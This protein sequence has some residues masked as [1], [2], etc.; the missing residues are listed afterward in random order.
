MLPHEASPRVIANG[1]KLTSISFKK[2]KIIDS[3]SF[4]PCSLDKLPKMFG[5]AELKKGFFPHNFNVPENFSYVGPYPSKEFYGYQ[6]FSQS[7]KEEF[8][9]WHASKANQVFN[10]KQEL[11]DYCISDVKLL[12]AA[13]LAFRDIIMS[14]TQK[15][16]VGIDPWV[17]SV[18]G[19]SLCLH[20]F[21]RNMMPV[22]SI[23][24]IPDYGYNPSNKTSLKCQQ[25][26]KGISQQQNI[27]IQHACNGGEF[28]VGKYLLDGIC[29]ENKTIYEF[30]GCVYHGC[31]SCYQPTTFNVLKQQSM[32]LVHSKHL[33][34]I[35]EIKKLMPDY[36]LVEIWEC[37][38]SKKNQL[39]HE[40]LNPRE[41]LFG[42]RTNAVKLYHKCTGTDTI[43]YMDYTSL[44][45]DVMKNGIF[46]IGHPKIITENFGPISSYF[47]LIKCR[48]LPPRQMYIPVLPARFNSKLVFALC[49]KCASEMNQD[50][51]FHNDF[52]RTLS[53]TW[54]SLEIME[55]LKHGYK[56]IE[57][58]EVWH[59]EQSSTTLF[60]DYINTFLKIKTE[61]SGFPHDD[62]DKFIRDFAEREGIKLDKDKIKKNLGLRSVAKLMLNSFWGRF[63]MNTNKTQY[64][65]LTTEAEWFQM[66][67]NDQFVIHDVD[68]IN[69]QIIQVFFSINSSFHAGSN[70]ANVP[71]AAF[72]TCQGRLKLFNELVKLDRRLLYFDTDSIIFVSK[73]G[74]FEPEL[75]DFLGQFTNEIDKAKGDFITEFVSAGPKNYAYK[76]NTGYSCCTVK[77]FN[78]NHKACELINFD[79]IKEIVCSAQEK[80]IQVDQ[81]KFARNK[82]SWNITTSTISKIY[83]FV[84]DK[85]VIISDYFT[86]PFGY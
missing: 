41:A 54:V 31:P 49:S 77:G 22:D 12:S 30:H 34:R 6:F 7:K 80:K 20:I 51:C 4:F 55:A 9:Q 82:H 24:V 32:G 28:H 33:A 71:I 56:L 75:G 58:I 17:S 14:V 44:Y 64:K 43:K 86:L 45:P 27:R 42:G 76:L 53:G 2:V 40:P 15:D 1:T 13:V 72:V 25:W 5:I 16:G 46:P 37:E 69:E 63:G 29:H 38:F 61:A 19:P 62:H 48:I 83:G 59:Y 39:T 10:F 78:L 84:Y 52:E 70:D 85:R 57:L 68:F 74:E 36:N 26:L 21:R 3:L 81:L 23:A 66:L 47:G 60:A 18:T 50:R 73:P 79:S 67:S 11:V 35:E 8:E 65:V